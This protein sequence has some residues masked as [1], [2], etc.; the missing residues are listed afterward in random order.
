MIGCVRQLGGSE[1]SSSLANPVEGNNHQ[2][3][4]SGTH[5]VVNSAAG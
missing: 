1:H 2:K 4:G 3:A 5:S